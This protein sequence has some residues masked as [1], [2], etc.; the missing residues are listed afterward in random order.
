[1]KNW[2]FYV[3]IGIC[4]GLASLLMAANCTSPKSS[5][6]TS[7]ASADAPAAGR[8]SQP[9]PSDT[10]P[11]GLPKEV[12]QGAAPDQAQVDLLKAAAEKERTISHGKKKPKN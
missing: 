9:L 1:M 3:K 7:P 10:L 4:S 8:S 11:P 12:G 6:T 5:K 2:S